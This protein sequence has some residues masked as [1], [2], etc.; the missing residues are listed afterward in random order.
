MRSTL[1]SFGTSE[2]R[3]TDSRGAHRGREHG[4]RFLRVS[5]PD[6]PRPGEREP[7]AN[8]NP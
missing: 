2:L 3:T 8:E 5:P 6:A 4:G 1:I 7:V